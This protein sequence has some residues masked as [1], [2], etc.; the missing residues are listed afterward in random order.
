MKNWKKVF[1][2]Y[3]I[4]ST[5]LIG[6]L[7][8]DAINNAFYKLDNSFKQTE[9]AVDIEILS[10]CINDKNISKDSL[11]DL[12]KRNSSHKKRG[13]SKRD[14]IKAN[15]IQLIYKEEKVVKIIKADT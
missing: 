12:L 15:T 7:I 3:F 1:W 11:I 8:Y 5:L 4:F 10:K 2:I 6:L 14:T 9:K 13:Y